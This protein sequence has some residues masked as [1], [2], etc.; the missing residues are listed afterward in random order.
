MVRATVSEDCRLNGV[1]DFGRW[2][3]AVEAALA[4]EGLID[5][6]VHD[7][8]ILIPMVHILYPVST[9][10][11]TT[12]QSKRAVGLANLA[13]NRQAAHSVIYQSL[14]PTVQNA[15]SKRVTNFRE[16]LPK[17]L[18]A[19]VSNKYGASS[20]TRRAELWATIF[21]E[22]IPENIDPEPA[23]SE[24]R[25]AGQ[26]IIASVTSETTINSFAQGVLA[27]AAIYRLPSSYGLLASTFTT[28]S[29]ELDDVINKVKAE[30]RRRSIRGDSVTA[31]GA[32]VSREVA[33]AAT[34]RMIGGT[35]GNKVCQYHP[36][37]S[38]HSTEECYTKG[39]SKKDRDR[40]KKKGIKAG[41]E[42]GA[43]ATESTEHQ[44]L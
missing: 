19:E 38:S 22:P 41:S 36:G 4:Q 18:F 13:K 28:D 35:P 8:S 33:A 30:H 7:F 1:D 39:K 17:E 42:T 10:P 37:M 27:F 16:P 14:G 15:L 34:Q 2:E 20:G 6:I 40:T 3:R 44:Q 31:E 26:L 5:H 23:L 21:G 11:T 32:L 29:I 12:E 9:P 43:L 25:Q 24:I